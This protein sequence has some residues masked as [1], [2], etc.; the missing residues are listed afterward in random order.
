LQNKTSKHVARQL[1]LILSEYG[2]T[3]ILQCDQKNEFKGNV[4]NLLKEQDVKVINSRPYHLQSQGK[5][6]R[7]HR[8]L[9]RMIGYFLQEDNNFSWAK[10]LHMIADSMNTTPKEVLGYQ[11]PFSVYYN[12]DPLFKTTHTLGYQMAHTRKRQKRARKVRKIASLATKRCA[13]RMVKTHFRNK[14]PSVYRKGE[15][16]L[17]RCPPG[18]KSRVPKRISIV[19]ARIIDRNMK[20]GRYKVGLEEKWANVDDI[21]S[22][23]VLQEE[24]RQKC[25]KDIY[26]LTEKK[27]KHKRKYFI[28]FK[29]NDRLE[30]FDM[31]DDGS[32]KIAFDPPGDGNCQFSAIAHQFSG[33]GI[34]RSPDALRSEEVQHLSLHSEHYEN[35]VSGDFQVYLR[36][37]S[38]NSTYGDHLT[39]QALTREYNVQCLVISSNGRNFDRLVSNTEEYSDHLSLLTLG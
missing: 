38:C 37:M 35:Y 22:T 34:H 31:F 21:T 7:S 5:C 18:G 8:I 27:S 16:V 33:Y 25:S 23:T 1:G 4:A 6:E 17:L 15:N 13:A 20:T 10:D 30:S 26:L 36:A 12:R 29:H 3:K 19:E 24:R 39:I 11:S 28:P 2:C 9:R 32:V 14:C